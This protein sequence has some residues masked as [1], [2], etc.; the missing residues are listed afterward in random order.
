M[1]IPMR[2]QTSAWVVGFFVYGPSF[3]LYTNTAISTPIIPRNIPKR[4]GI[5]VEGSLGG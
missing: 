1:N 3:P 5:I 4:S 2:L